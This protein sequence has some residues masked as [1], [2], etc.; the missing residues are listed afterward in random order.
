M[1]G[2]EIPNNVIQEC[3]R[4]GGFGYI[5]NTEGK[6]VFSPRRV[7]NC[8]AILDIN[9]KSDL[10]VP[11]DIRDEMNE[12]NLAYTVIGQDKEHSKSF[13]PDRYF[14][15]VGYENRIYIYGIQDCYTLVREYF[16]DNYDVWIPSNIAREFGW[17]NNGQNLY[18]DLHKE[19]GFNETTDLIRKD[20]VLLFKLDEGMPC[21]SAIY[22]GGGK[23][24][25]H[26]MSR[27]SCIEPFDGIY[28]T[29]LVGVLR[30]GQ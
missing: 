30:Y 28:K 15:K 22:I 8:V 6:P 10:T 23:I 26:M 11:A 3:I 7:D 18:V 14:E 29:S 13:L 27:F 19:Y 5:K 20:D 17:W 24:L 4:A 1:F 12:F 25:H 9:P 16:R 21:H 2:L